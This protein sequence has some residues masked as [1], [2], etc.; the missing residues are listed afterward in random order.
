MLISSI[1]L[2][3]LQSASQPGSCRNHHLLICNCLLHQPGQHVITLL[4]L[5]GNGFCWIYGQLYWLICDSELLSGHSLC[6]A[7][8]SVVLRRITM[9]CI[10]FHYIRESSTIWQ[11]SIN[12]AVM[13]VLEKFFLPLLATKLNYSLHFFGLILVMKYSTLTCPSQDWSILQTKKQTFPWPF[14]SIVVDVLGT[15]LPIRTEFKIPRTKFPQKQAESQYCLP[16]PYKGCIA[17]RCVQVQASV[18]D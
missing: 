8:C 12:F 3:L 5:L 11:C 18:H 16:V 7:G 2:L 17:G 15:V 10:D 4:P 14:G 1:P 13:H 9:C 6:A